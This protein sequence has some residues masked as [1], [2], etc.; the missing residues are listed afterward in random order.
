[1]PTP[2]QMIAFVREHTHFLG[3]LSARS[4]LQDDLRLCGDDIEELLTEY[5][6]R[7]GVDRATY[8]WYF[9][10]G[11]ESGSGSVGAWFFPPPNAR[12]E[13]IPITIA[14]LCEFANQG[15]WGVKYPE[16]YIPGRRYDVVVNAIVFF[17]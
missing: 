17:V 5:S 15:S 3:E 16:H 10:T 14:M 13:E 11:E 2:D 4:S 1:M 12:V 8:L 9:H 7:F 6:K